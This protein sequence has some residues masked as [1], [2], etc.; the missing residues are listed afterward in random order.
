MAKDKII[1]HGTP[2]IKA[3]EKALSII[4][5]SISRQLGVPLTATYRKMTPDEMEALKNRVQ[6]EIK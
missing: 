6:S 4:V 5:Q 3:Q 1:I 2:S